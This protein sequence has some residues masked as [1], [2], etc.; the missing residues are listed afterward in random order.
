MPFRLKEAVS[1]FC[2]VAGLLPGGQNALW[3]QPPTPPVMIIA[4]CQHRVCERTN[5]VTTLTTPLQAGDSPAALRPPPPVGMVQICGH[6]GY[7]V[8]DITRTSGLAVILPL[9]GS[10]MP[11]PAR[12]SADA[13]LSIAKIRPTAL[14]IPSS[15]EYPDGGPDFLHPGTIRIRRAL[16]PRYRCQRESKHHHPSSAFQSTPYFH[17]QQPYRNGPARLIMWRQRYGRNRQLRFFHQPRF[18]QQRE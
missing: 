15:T 3:A 16:Q 9:S 12:L 8:V 6:S 10:F 1:A 4:P 11:A 14:S 5:R 2:L 7:S 13:R 18:C 17:L